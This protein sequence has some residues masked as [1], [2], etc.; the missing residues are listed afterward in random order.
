M[1]AYHSLEKSNMKIKF[2]KALYILFIFIIQNTYLKSQRVIDFSHCNDLQPFIESVFD[3]SLFFTDYVDRALENL[4]TFQTSCRYEAHVLTIQGLRE[5]YSNNIM[6]S[7]NVL[8]KAD[9]LYKNQEN[10]IDKYYIRNQIFL[11]QNYDVFTDTIRSLYYLNNAFSLAS[12]IQNASL[13][14]DAAHSLAVVFLN[15]KNY[16]KAEEFVEQSLDFCKLSNNKE[17]AAFANLTKS[18]ILRSE[19]RF[20]AALESIQEARTIF[21]EKSDSIN[22]YL[23]ELYTAEVFIEDKKP[24]EAIEQLLIAELIGDRQEHKVQHGQIYFHLGNIYQDIDTETSVQYF[25]KAFEF[26][27]QLSDTKMA[28]VIDILAKNYSK[29]KRYDK[30][31]ELIG[32]LNKFYVEKK[33]EIKLEFAKSNQ[34]EIAIQKEQSD[35][36]ILKIQNDFNGKIIKLVAIASVLF[37]LMALYAGFQW[38][39]NK[40]LNTLIGIKNEQLINQNKELKNFASIAS[41][42]LKAPSNSIYSFSKLIEKLLP[43]SSDPKVFKYLD[44]IKTSSSNMNS[45]VNSLLEFTK[46]EQLKVDNS[47]LDVRNLLNEVVNN[48]HDLISM[49]EAQIQIDSNLPELIRGD[50]TLLRIVFQNLI[51]NALKFTKDDVKPIVNIE[52]GESESMHI[53][54]IIDNGIGIEEEYLEK[55]F[56]IFQRLHA[57]S[58]F[59][60]SGIGL[61]TCKKIIKLHKG[62]ITIESEVGK[63]ST[64]SVILPKE[65]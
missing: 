12:E 42:D 53:F 20:D 1:T 26:S 29:Q 55:I 59:E 21:L 40:K 65:L 38:N 19:A 62:K 6:K 16:K 35:K 14:A 8:L 44:I 64:F 37:L 36:K 47:F 50:E 31:V 56:R 27:Q 5:F 58:K 41:H 3:S 45:L 60:G 34:K 63:G 49:N 43:S 7:R 24:K 2:R 11:G 51:G 48:L 33:D 22:L 4:D 9:S 39:K 15:S 13:Q 17:I 18:R 61:S 52:Y 28:K 32:G 10:H 23:V 57:S 25:E 46:L 54:K 30:Q